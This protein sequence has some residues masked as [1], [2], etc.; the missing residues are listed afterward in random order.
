[1]AR[2]GGRI[3]VQEYDVDGA[4]DEPRLT[5]HPPFPPFERLIAAL[6][7]L[8][9][10]RGTPDFHAGRKALARFIR[11]GLTDL[12]VQGAAGYMAFTD[13]RME[14]SFGM[15]TRPEAGERLAAA[16][17]MDA[18]DFAAVVAEIRRAHADPAFDGVVVRGRT[19]VATVGVRPA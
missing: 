18:A 6:W 14:I 12:R 2:P 10:A 15:V 11:A 3:A 5:C 19:L 4:T 17:V 16:G 9:S 13:P 7:K 8:A 1:L